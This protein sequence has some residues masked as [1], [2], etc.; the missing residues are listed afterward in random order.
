MIGFQIFA[1]ILAV[2]FCFAFIA[3]LRSRPGMVSRFGAIIILGVIVFLI[4]VLIDPNISWRIA[5]IAGVGRGSDMMSYLAILFLLFT[6]A[7]LYLRTKKLQLM[8]VE[9]T[10]S[11]SILQVEQDAKL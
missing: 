2:V 5:E 10:R 7:A 6:S 4:A 11:I 1:L 3:L 9:L 8:I